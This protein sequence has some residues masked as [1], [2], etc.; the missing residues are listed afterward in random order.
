M[1]LSL[2]IATLAMSMAASAAAWNAARLVGWRTV[3]TRPIG[4]L[5]PPPGVDPAVWRHKRRFWMCFYGAFAWS[6][7]LQLVLF[8]RQS[9]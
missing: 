6:M 7:A 4:W 3:L 5:R 9:A 8:M 1:I 2:V